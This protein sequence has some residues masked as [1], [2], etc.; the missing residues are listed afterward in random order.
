MRAGEILEG[1]DKMRNEEI[2]K[3]IG[4]I[5]NASVANGGTKIKLS[6]LAEILKILD[7]E[8]DLWDYYK[9][10]TDGIIKKVY[11]YFIGKGDQQ[12]ADNIKNTYI[13]KNG[14]ALIP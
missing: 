5:A 13:K 9:N 12:T 4:A 10:R 11:D 8:S 2:Y 3:L 7:I 1:G 14:E 6:E